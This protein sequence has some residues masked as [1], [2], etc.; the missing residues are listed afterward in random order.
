[1]V[2]MSS[3]KAHVRNGYFVSDEPANLPEGTPVELQLV[4]TDPWAGMA[5]Q[6]RAELEEA[7]EEGYR[8]IENGNVVDAREFLAELRA[9]KA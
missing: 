7:I 8:D 6:E 9:K 2:D 3:V 1:M 5:P 4:T